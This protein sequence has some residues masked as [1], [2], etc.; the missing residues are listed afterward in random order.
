MHVSIKRNGR[1]TFVITGCVV[2]A[3]PSI[4]TALGLD[5]IHLEAPGKS[6]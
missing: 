3:G 2:I 1:G 5:D 6:S 4:T